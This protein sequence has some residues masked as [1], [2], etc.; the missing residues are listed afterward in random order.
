MEETI[1]AKIVRGE[2]SADVIYE[3]E[4]LMVFKDIAPV[5]PIHW[6]AIPKK[7]IVNVDDLND[8]DEAV[9]GQIF[10]TIRRLAREYGF[11]E[12]GYRVTT[13]C[14]RE[15]GQEVYHL[16]FHILA[17]RQLKSIG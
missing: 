16:H 14:N 6:L 1:F 3:N 8:E 4:Q 17:G 5:A 7:P 11:A 13:N 10:T 15:G 2:I 12:S 9:V